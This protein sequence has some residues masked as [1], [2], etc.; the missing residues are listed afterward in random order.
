MQ[1]LPLHTAVSLS[2]PALHDL[3]PDKVYPSLH[4][5]EQE[6][7]CARLKVQA[8]PGAP[9]E[10]GPAALHELPLHTAVSL[11]TPALHDLCPDKVY[12]VLQ[13]TVQSPEFE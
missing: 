6:D 13:N 7:P 2:S 1:S 8:E 4:V 11:R 5:G 3:C 10:M 12:P 9:L